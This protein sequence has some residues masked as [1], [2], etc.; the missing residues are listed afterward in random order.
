MGPE[1]EPY[2]SVVIPPLV[3]AVSTKAAISI[4]GTPIPQLYEGYN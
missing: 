1:F 2:L 3:N 4:Y